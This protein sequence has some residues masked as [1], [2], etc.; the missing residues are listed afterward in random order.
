MGIVFRQSVKNS[1]VT[2][3]GAILGALVIWLSTKY[4]VDKQ[5][6]G[7]TR[8]LTQQAVTLAMFLCLGINNTLVVFIHRF[9][10][11]HAK[12]KVLLTVSLFL[13]FLA[14]M[15]LTLPYIIFKQWIVHHYQPKDIPLMDKYYLWLPIYALLFVYLSVLEQFLGSQMK[16]AVAAFMREIVVRVLSIALLLLFAFNLISF[17]SLV[18]GSVIIYIVPVSIFFFLSYKTGV[19]GFSF[20]WNAFNKAEYKEII[21]FSWY[22]FLLT[23]STNLLAALDMLLIPFYDHKGLNSVAIYSIAV[24]L[25]SF[26]Q[27]PYKAMIPGSFTVMARAFAD[28]D[29]PKARDLFARSSLNILIATILMVVLISCNLN[30][31]VAIIKNN[32]SDVIPVFLILMV[33]K[34]FDIATGMNDQVLSITNYYKFNFY[35]SI[36]L[37]FVLFILIRI[38]VPLY[39]INGA[40]LSTAIVILAFNTIK[41]IFVW[42]KLSMRTFNTNTLKILLAGGITAAVGYFLPKLDN[43][44]IDIVIRSTSIVIVYLAGMVWLKPSPDLSAYFASIKEHKRLF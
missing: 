7:F 41:Y 2:A 43:V 29:L 20:K 37:V 9:Y 5:Q 28:N 36:A 10:E 16:V 26:L 8:N 1:I 15:I 13:P 22:H 34:T 44:L 11:Y 6:F 4:I 19:F 30:N 33:G 32:Y 31:A 40:A 35:V 38:L 17:H 12:R 27:L 25:I 24:F 21:H 18:I 14:T 3:L 23:I 39:S 42:K